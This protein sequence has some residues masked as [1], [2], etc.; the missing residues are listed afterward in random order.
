MN[1]RIIYCSD[2]TALKNKLVEDGYFDEEAQSFQTGCTLTPIKHKNGKSLSVARHLKLDLKEYT[3]LEDFGT[4]DELFSNPTNLA[5]YKE[6]WDY[7]KEHIST[8]MDGTT[9]VYKKPKKIGRFL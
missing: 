4:Y 7:E 1:N 9:S 2:V 3:M 8:N 5:K 6:V